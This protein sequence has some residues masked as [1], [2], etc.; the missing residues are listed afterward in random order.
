MQMDGT[1]LQG[2]TTV[3]H[4]WTK[5]NFTNFVYSGFRFN[6]T[7]AGPTASYKRCYNN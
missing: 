1:Y 3:I 2:I 7:A 6:D 5:I 4:D